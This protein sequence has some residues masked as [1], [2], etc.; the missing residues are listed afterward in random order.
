MS[1]DDYIPKDGEEGECRFST[2]AMSELV[3]NLL[4]A[5]S[6]LGWRE[7]ISNALDAMIH[8]AGKKG[9]KEQRV[10][11]LRTNV[12]GN[13]EIEDIGHA[14]FTDEE[15][16]RFLFIGEERGYAD[17]NISDLERIGKFRMGKNALIALSRVGVVKFY[18]HA[19]R[20]GIKRGLVITIWKKSKKDPIRY[21]IQHMD[22]INALSHPGL[23]VEIIEAKPITTNRLSNLVSKWFAVHVARDVQIIIDGQ[24][25]RKPDGFDSREE[26]LFRLD[27]GSEI[28]GNLKHVEKPKSNNIEIRVRGVFIQD[29]DVDYKVQGWINYPF[30]ELTASREKIRTDEDTLYPEFESKFDAH[31]AEKYERKDVPQ[32]EGIKDKKLEE[33][34]SRAIVKYYQN[35]P[36]HEH[37]FLKGRVSKTELRGTSL[38]GG[39]L[40]EKVKQRELVKNENPDVGGQK[41]IRRVKKRRTKK[42][43]K[44]KKKTPN[45]PPVIGP[46]KVLAEEGAPPNDNKY[47]MLEGD[48]NFKILQQDAQEEEEEEEEIIP[49]VNYSALPR[50][51]EKPLVFY[52]KDEDAFIINISHEAR[53]IFIHKKHGRFHEVIRAIV[54]AVPQ[55]HGLLV[56]EFNKRYYQLLNDMLSQME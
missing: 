27:D 15:L 31:L 49:E 14:I 24:R 3:T 42:K 44:T 39:E 54:A 40:W 51:K 50:T 32:P 21:K 12:K 47:D 6:I 48:R 4:Y 18:S 45:K 55:N 11:Q 33:Y 7:G 28:S 1:V 29:I 56:E 30:F 26:P 5:N 23:K 41:L 25:V 8:L 10:I 9:Q 22:S 52:D 17:S 38:K 53:D 34:T 16:K 19:D 43:E 20:N 13:A 37:I 36:E 46:P 35:N 2:V